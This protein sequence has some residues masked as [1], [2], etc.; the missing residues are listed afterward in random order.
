[1]KTANG[2]PVAG[3]LAG[4]TAKLGQAFPH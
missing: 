1:M 2:E 3:S 4:K